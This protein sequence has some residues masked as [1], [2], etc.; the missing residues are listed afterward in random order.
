V[1][2]NNSAI[3]VSSLQNDNL[4]W[5]R[6]TGPNIGLDFSM[7]NNRLTGSIDV[8]DR[9]TT[10]MIVSRSTLAI[11]GL[12]SQNIIP[13]GPDNSG[14]LTNIGQVNNKGFELLLEGK[15]YQSKN[16]NWG[17]SGTFVLNRNKIKS[18]YGPTT[19]KDASGNTVTREKDDLG[20]GWFIGKDVNIVWDYV[21][22]GVWQTP[23]AV[24]KLLNT[25]QN[26]ATLNCRT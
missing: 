3:Y 16:F 26:Q 13:G 11:Q 5:E 6:T 21:I 18:L 2:V 24:R 9:K 22:Q 10:D 17:A 1:V 4:S 8:Y 12:N 7:L 23:E 25:V 15:I 14:V 19:F 20:N